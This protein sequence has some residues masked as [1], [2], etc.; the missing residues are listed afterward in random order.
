MTHNEQQKIYD[1]APTVAVA[2]T[3]QVQGPVMN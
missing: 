1:V 3:W 2:Q